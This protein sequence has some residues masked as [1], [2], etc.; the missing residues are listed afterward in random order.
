MRL[1]SQNLTLSTDP[2]AKEEGWLSQKT[3]WNSVLLTDQAIDRL[4]KSRKCWAESI[5]TETGFTSHWKKSDF[6]FQSC[7]D[8]VCHLATVSQLTDVRLFESSLNSLVAI[9]SIG[10]CPI[11][12]HL[13]QFHPAKPVIIRVVWVSLNYVERTINSFD[14]CHFSELRDVDRQSC[15]VQV[16]EQERCHMYPKH[17]GT[18]R[19]A[20]M[21]TN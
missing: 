6:L 1:I 10:D 7:S 18:C 11:S 13:D 5:F 4:I 9:P 16:T 8:E 3:H 17:T 12:L 21:K 14:A 15:I 19:G 20:R 2:L